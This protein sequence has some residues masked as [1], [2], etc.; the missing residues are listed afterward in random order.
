METDSDLIWL[1]WK[2]H[3]GIN[4]SGLVPPP[5]FD[6]GHVG[7]HLTTNREYNGRQLPVTDQWLMWLR[8]NSPHWNDASCIGHV[9]LLKTMAAAVGILVR[10]CWVYPT[11]KTLPDH[12]EPVIADAD[13][14]ALG[15]SDQRKGRRGFSIMAA[16]TTR[17]T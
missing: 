4:N 3:V 9:Q 13:C 2:L 12:S 7:R 10:R 17:P 16:E 11:T 8:T 14:Y 5:Y 6:P 1:L 15:A